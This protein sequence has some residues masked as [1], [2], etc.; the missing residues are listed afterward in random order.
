[1]Q[2]A[3]LLNVP[4]ENLD[5][6]WGTRIVLDLDVLY[7]NIVVRRRGG[8]CYELGGL[9]HGLLRQL[10]FD[11][12]PAMGRVYNRERDAYGP[13]YDHMLILADCGGVTW[14]VDV[15]FYSGALGYALRA[16]DRRTLDETPRDLNS[17]AVRIWSSYRGEA[18]SPLSRGTAREML[19][20]QVDEVGL[21]WHLPRAG[22]SRFQHGGG[23]AAL[24]RQ[25]LLSVEYGNDSGSMTNG[26]AGEGVINE[27]AEPIGRAYRWW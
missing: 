10:G 26:G 27:L 12:R 25:L 14:L 5:I 22:A 15:G 17:F 4:F 21:G 13:A 16:G 23:N 7:E 20:R 11:A 3:L 19:A 8:F 24:R 9:F 18:D 1:L 2:E 6:F